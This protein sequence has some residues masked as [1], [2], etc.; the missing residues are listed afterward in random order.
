MIALAEFVNFQH[1]EFK[2]KLSSIQKVILKSSYLEIRSVFLPSADRIHR[3]HAFDIELLFIIN[4]IYDATS[5][6]RKWC[7]LKLVECGNVVFFLIFF[8]LVAGSDGNVVPFK[9]HKAAT[10]EY[11]SLNEIDRY[12]DWYRTVYQIKHTTTHSKEHSSKYFI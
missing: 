4:I 5:D 10:S 9:P 8:N 1:A 7:I 6:A 12:K 11:F 3:C 2:T